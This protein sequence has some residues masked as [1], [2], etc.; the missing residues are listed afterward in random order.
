MGKY[1]TGSAKTGEK[2]MENFSDFS[3]DFIEID[4]SSKNPLY[5]F[6]W[7]FN[8]QHGYVSIRIKEASN[9]ISN[10]SLIDTDRASSHKFDRPLGLYNDQTL[11]I[12]FKKMMKS[13]NIDVM[14]VY[15]DN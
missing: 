9:K 1:L 13:L 2:I 10:G 5:R 3:Y 4:T 8:S 6:S 12:V 11:F 14:E 15:D 7:R